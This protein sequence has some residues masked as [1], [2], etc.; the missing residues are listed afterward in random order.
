MF[1]KGVEITFLTYDN[2][3]KMLDKYL[4][5]NKSIPEKLFCTRDMDNNYIGADN[6]DGKFFAETFSKLDDCV[7]WL[8]DE[9][10]YA[11]EFTSYIW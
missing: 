3:L 4:E 5:D 10:A 2:Y 1:N 8:V 7:T 11:P 9:S 6:T